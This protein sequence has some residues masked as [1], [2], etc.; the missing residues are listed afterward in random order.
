M[1]L[2]DPN[3][4]VAPLLAL[5]CCSAVTRLE[6]QIEAFEADLEALSGGEGR[7]SSAELPQCVEELE[8]LILRHR[9]HIIRMEQV[10][11]LLE[12]DQARDRKAHCGQT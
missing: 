1:M 12:N 9:Q 4:T 3:Q 2:E 7:R 11:R 8:V 6:E 5:P 10:L